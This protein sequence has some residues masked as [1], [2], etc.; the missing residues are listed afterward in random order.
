[1]E[2]IGDSDLFRHIPDEFYKMFQDE[3]FF[4]IT[5]KQIKNTNNIDISSQML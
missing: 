2:V 4:V 3:I 5:S 1:M